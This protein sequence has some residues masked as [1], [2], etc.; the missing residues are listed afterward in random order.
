MDVEFTVEEDVAIF[1][2][3]IDVFTNPSVEGFD[4]PARNI[5]H[6]VHSKFEERFSNPNRRSKQAIRIRVGSVQR[7]VK[8]YVS[9]QGRLIIYVPPAFIT[10]DMDI[11]PLQILRMLTPYEG[12]LRRVQF[13]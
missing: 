2:P 10:A 13:E 5:W 9:L 7:D 3:W 1:A 8:L 4:R 11:P 6:Q 12:R